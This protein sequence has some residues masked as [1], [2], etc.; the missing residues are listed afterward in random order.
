VRA[1][2]L[3]LASDL[4]DLRDKPPEPL[5]PS[6][7]ALGVWELAWPTI[8]ASAMQTLVR[9]VDLKMV[10]SLGVGALAGCS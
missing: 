9:W 10:G 2:S 6:P 8:V 1:E 5:A 3:E 7:Q 4:L